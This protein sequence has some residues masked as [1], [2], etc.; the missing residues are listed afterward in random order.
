M[1]SFHTALRALGIL[2]S[3]KG[4]AMRIEVGK[5][6]GLSEY[7]GISNILGTI[8]LDGQPGT[9]KM[10]HLGH[11][12]ISCSRL[13]YSHFHLH[14]PDFSIL[15]NAAIIHPLAQAR[16]FIASLYSSLFHLPDVYSI[17]EF[18]RLSVQDISRVWL[19][20]ISTV[21]MSVW[22]TTVSHINVCHDLLVF[23]DPTLPAWHLFHT[24][25]STNQIMLFPC[26]KHFKDFPL[27]LK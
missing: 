12:I 10:D 19:L 3:L 1:L 14:T 4:F 6:G 20:I 21:K 27:H 18:C 7:I 8:D 5:K 24:V 2:R 9:Y 25:A 26:L 15:V 23:L 22:A 17:A 11:L 13:S 16:N